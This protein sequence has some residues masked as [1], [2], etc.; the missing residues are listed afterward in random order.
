MAT[1]PEQLG[2]NSTAGASQ[3]S[4]MANIDIA[5]E[6]DVIFVLQ[7][8]RLRVSSVILSSASP[9]FKAM[10]GPNFAE[11]QGN[12]SAG[13]PREVSLFDD[14]VSAMTRLCRILHH[15]DE[16][17]DTPLTSIGP[18]D[19]CVDGLFALTVVSDKYGCTDSV[20]V[21]VK[22]L[23]LELA[24]TSVSPL[25]S[26]MSLVVLSAV[27][28]K[29]NDCRHFA[30]FSRRLV[31]DISFNYSSLAGQHE[32]EALPNMFLCKYTMLNGDRQA[33]ANDGNSAS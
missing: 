32:L 27:A 11:G 20:K 4:E 2:E 1:D 17:K 16:T 23:L 8:T 3:P 26:P 24:S 5:A 19:S 25:V 29:I 33:A 6:G 9:V 12:R 30:L 13:E 31:L 10:F 21:V 28:Y 15:Q 22:Y 14:D 7:Q 18:V